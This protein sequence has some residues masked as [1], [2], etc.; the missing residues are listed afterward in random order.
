M[1]PPDEPD[2]ARRCAHSWRSTLKS[3]GAAQQNWRKGAWA[4]AGG[5]DGASEVSFLGL[6]ARDCGP[7][8]P[9]EGRSVGAE[10]RSGRLR[11]AT[12]DVHLGDTTFRHYR[13]CGLWSKPPRARTSG[14]RRNGPME[15]SS[16][17]SMSTPLADRGQVAPVGAVV[18]GEFAGRSGLIAVPPPPRGDC[19]LFF[20]GTALRVSGRSVQAGQ[21]GSSP[22]PGASASRDR[23]GPRP[24]SA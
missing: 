8:E 9:R 20:V 7:N 6:R 19:V 11:A 21:P 17:S 10:S 3:P 5:P 4:G 16:G 2:L 18:P 15:P 23:S 1:A 13:A 24:Q 14:R 22:E 12:V